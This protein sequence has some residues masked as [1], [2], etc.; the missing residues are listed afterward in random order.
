[1]LLS[2]ASVFSGAEV[3]VKGDWN[4][5]AA[6]T[7]V[8]LQLYVRGRALDDDAPPPLATMRSGCACLRTQTLLVLYHARRTISI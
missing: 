1:V 4:F 6:Y 8:D 7:A 2:T 5:Y 3:A